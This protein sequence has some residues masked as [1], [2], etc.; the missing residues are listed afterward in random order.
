MPRLNLLW[1]DLRMVVCYSNCLDERVVLGC[2]N[3]LDERMVCCD[4]FGLVELINGVVLV[5]FEAPLRWV[6]IFVINSYHFSVGV[7]W[8]YELPLFGFNLRVTI[9]LLRLNTGV[10]IVGFRIQI[11]VWIFGNSFYVPCRLLF[12]F[13]PFPNFCSDIYFFLLNFRAGFKADFTY[14]R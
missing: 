2:S 9:I 5:S 14:A 3:C 4:G 12:S 8:Y 11:S 6:S 10:R 13:V 7:C 1:L